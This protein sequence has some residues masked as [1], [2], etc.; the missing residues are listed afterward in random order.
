MPADLPPV[1]ELVQI[2]T[3]A[4]GK[5]VSALRNGLFYA[6]NG[7]G[8]WSPQYIA[9]WCRVLVLPDTEETAERM[10]QAF[11]DQTY[12]SNHQWRTLSGKTRDMHRRN[13]SAVLAAVRGAAIR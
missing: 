11:V 8:C 12:S 13:M 4:D 3:S 2:T 6:A 7:D 10:A 9:S 1:G 5:V